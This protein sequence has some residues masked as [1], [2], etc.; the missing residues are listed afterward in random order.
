RAGALERHAAAPP[1]L[2]ARDVDRL[3][4]PGGHRGRAREL[5]ADRVVALAERERRLV[6]ED[7][8][9][10]AD[11]A[12]QQRD[13]RDEVPAVGGDRTLHGAAP[14]ATLLTFGAAFL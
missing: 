9:G 13:D 3:A 2:H 11:R 4:L 6:S 1:P 10:H 12:E 5:R 7:V 8:G 14:V